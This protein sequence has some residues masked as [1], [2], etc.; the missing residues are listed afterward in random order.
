MLEVGEDRRS[1]LVEESVPG[2]AVEFGAQ[3][4][5]L[6]AD[7]GGLLAGVLDLQ[8]GSHEIEWDLIVALE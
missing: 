8:A 6:G 1:G 7:F 5:G 4:V 2:V 3:E